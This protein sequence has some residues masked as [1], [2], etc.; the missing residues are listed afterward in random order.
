MKIFKDKKCP[1]CSHPITYQDYT[2][3]QADNKNETEEPVYFTCPSCE[4]IILSFCDYNKYSEGLYLFMTYF[5]VG[6]LYFYHTVQTSTY[7]VLGLLILLWASIDYFIIYPRIT[8]RCLTHKQAHK[9]DNETFC[10]GY[11]LFFTFL[12]I[13]GLG[14]IL[15]SLLSSIKI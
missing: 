4:H 11:T 2:N 13:V 6:A 7:I 1:C 9:M 10:G 14:M 12:L 3:F 5:T 15:F 8:L